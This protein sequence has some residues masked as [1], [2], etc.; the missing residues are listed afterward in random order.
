MIGKS[1]KK[2]KECFEFVAAGNPSLATYESAIM[3][4]HHLTVLTLFR[5]IGFVLEMG[6][7]AILHC[8]LH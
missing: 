6:T 4:M 7:K 2:K 3:R 8:L 1:K 5:L